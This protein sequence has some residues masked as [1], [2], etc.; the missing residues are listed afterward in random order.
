MD[1][2]QIGIV[3]SLFSI[4]IAV[5]KISRNGNNKD[6]VKRPD[7]HSAMDTQINMFNQR[8]DDLKS[9]IDTRFEDI[10]DFIKNRK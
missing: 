6:F 9:H 5:L 10:K 4:S 8:M 3:V 2:T 7:C 1:A